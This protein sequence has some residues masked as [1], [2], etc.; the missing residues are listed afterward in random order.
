MVQ[1]VVLDWLA[2]ILGMGK[3]VPGKN[4]R[5]P[6]GAKSVRVNSKPISIK[7]GLEANIVSYQ[8]D[9]T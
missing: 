3:C 6:N 7:H 2:R 4:K 8:N 1:K 9:T 5:N